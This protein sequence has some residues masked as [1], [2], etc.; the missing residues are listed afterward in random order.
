MKVRSARDRRQRCR[1]QQLYRG[2]WRRFH[3]KWYDKPMPSAQRLCLE[4]VHLLRSLPAVRGAMFALLP[5]DGRLGRHG[6]PFAGNLRYH[7]GL[8]TPNSDACGIEV[9]G[10]AFLARRQRRGVR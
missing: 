8:C 5:P 2:R 3:L 6:D 7:L 10:R 4:T 1:V 9:D